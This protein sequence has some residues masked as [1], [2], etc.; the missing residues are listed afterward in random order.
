MNSRSDL[1]GS[2]PASGAQSFRA[3]AARW[4]NGCSKMLHYATV[5]AIISLTMVIMGFGSILASFWNDEK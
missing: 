2:A 5:F 1:I 4:L 3:G